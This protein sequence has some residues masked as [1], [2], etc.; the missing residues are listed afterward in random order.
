[1]RHNKKLNHLSR[2]RG[3][4]HAMLRNMASSLIVHKRI[5]TTLAKAKALRIYVE[6]VIT[7]S[8]DNTMHARRQAFRY[9]QDKHAV[10]ELFAEVAPAVGDRPGGY[11]RVIRTGTR[12]GDNAETAII[13]L[14]DFNTTYSSKSE[15]KKA[16]TRRSRRRRRSSDSNDAGAT[17]TA[18][19][20]SATEPAQ[21]AAEVVETAE[22]EASEAS[23]QVTMTDQTAQVQE[24][25]P[26]GDADAS[27]TGENLD[28]ADGEEE[29]P[30]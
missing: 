30:A 1:M 16:R 3:H 11:V 2:Q 12:L 26:M 13:E 18:A 21:A 19:A 6:P 29:K 8:K 23:E 9:L 17:N 4:R 15:P 27:G 5:S 20:E 10:K 22:V 7:K 25:T 24:T 14:V 28:S